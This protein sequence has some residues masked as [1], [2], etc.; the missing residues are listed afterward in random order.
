MLAEGLVEL[1]MPDLFYKSYD[2]IDRHALTFNEGQ[3]H[4]ETNIVIKSRIKSCVAA[5]TR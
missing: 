3:T 5:A 4:Q 1:V 2:F